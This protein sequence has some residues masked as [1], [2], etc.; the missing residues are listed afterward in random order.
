MTTSLSLE[1]R[2][3]VGGDLVQG[4]ASVEF[5]SAPFNGQ[6]PNCDW[7]DLPDTG[8]GVGPDNYVTLSHGPGVSTLIGPS[9]IMVS[10]TYLGNC[11]DGEPNGQPS[12]GPPYSPALKD[13][14]F[15]PHGNS[16]QYPGTLG[17]CT[18]SGGISGNDEDGVSQGPG[19]G[20]GAWQN[21]GG[22]GSINVLGT[23]GA[24]FNGWIDWNNNGLLTDTDEQVAT[25]VATLGATQNITFTIPAGTLTSGTQYFYARYRLTEG[26][27]DYANGGAAP[28]D[29]AYNGE[30]EDYYHTVQHTTAATVVD[31]TAA[32]ADAFVTLHWATGDERTLRGFNILAAAA[33]ERPAVQVNTAMIAAQAGGSIDGAAYTWRDPA[34]LAAGEVRYYWLEE[35]D[36]AGGTTPHG[37][38]EVSAAAHTLFLPGVFRR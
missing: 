38:L 19:P 27:K 1:G 2:V 32:V 24:C 34:P 28:T 26:C 22:G 37:P 11:V 6:T 8:I 12:N 23:N 20:G 10:E 30:V 16:P 29:V 35:V 36:L 15:A 5:R 25:N 33:A 31:A 18:T 7:G 17:T 3:L 9:H 13:D 14:K 21:G 4:R